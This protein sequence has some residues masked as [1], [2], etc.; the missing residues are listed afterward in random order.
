MFAPKVLPTQGIL[1]QP[2]AGNT[3]RG[4]A[5]TCHNQAVRI[6]LSA[7]AMPPLFFP[8]AMPAGSG[9]PGHGPGEEKRRHGRRTQKKTKNPGALG[10]AGVKQ[11]CCGMVSGPCHSSDRRSPLLRIIC[12]ILTLSPE[13]GRAKQYP[14]LSFFCPSPFVL[15]PSKRRPSVRRSWRG[16]ETTPQPSTGFGENQAP[17]RPRRESERKERRPLFL[18]AVAM[19][20]L[21]LGARIGAPDVKQT[22][23][24]PSVRRVAWSGNHATTEP[25]VRP[26]QGRGTTS[27]FHGFRCAPPVATIVCPLAGAGHSGGSVLPGHA[28]L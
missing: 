6:F 13:A 11:P 24:R 22:K 4:H 15:C 25:L 10:R 8:Q 3:R 27:L 12:A 17:L 14:S 5:R 26:F 20:P 28:N 1:S 9:T 18:T 21:W 7:A 16:L 19:P 23:R 2:C